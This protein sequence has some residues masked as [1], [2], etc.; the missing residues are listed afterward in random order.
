MIVDGERYPYPAP[1]KMYWRP[2][3]MVCE[4]TVAGVSIREE[5]FIAAN[6]VVSTT[7]TASREI[8]VEFDG[9][10]FMPDGGSG[11]AEQIVAMNST[12][13]FDTSNNALHIIEG[14]IVKAE[15]M[16][17]PDVRVNATLMYDGMSTV[18]SAT[19]PFGNMTMGPWRVRVH[20]QLAVPC[21]GRM[22]GKK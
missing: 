5:K 9:H 18:I 19:K 10:S 2:D 17:N 8:V 22:A 4:Y 3:K 7:I 13:N 14:G 16:Q 21:V 1:D 11:G 12:C 6:D 20:F 15:V